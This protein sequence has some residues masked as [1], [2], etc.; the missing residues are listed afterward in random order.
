MNLLRASVLAG[1]FFLTTLPTFSADSALV[2]RSKKFL[3]LP[4]VVKSIETSW[5]FGA[6]GSFFFKFQKS[7]F[8]PLSPGVKTELFFLKK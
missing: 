7:H 6:A 4:A 8:F 5:A 3:I 2:S 1:L